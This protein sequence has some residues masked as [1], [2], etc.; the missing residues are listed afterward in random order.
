[1]R[2]LKV[3]FGYPSQPERCL[4]PFTLSTHKQQWNYILGE[5]QISRT[6]ELA[7]QLGEAHI[8]RHHML[9]GYLHF[10]IHKI[11]SKFTWIHPQ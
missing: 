2:L 7:E 5:A 1:M 10:R 6:F 8:S 4:G 3:G 9:G 11:M